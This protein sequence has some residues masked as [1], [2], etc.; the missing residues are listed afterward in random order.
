MPERYA[1]VS[2]GIT[3]AYEEVGDPGA[4]PL[5][6]VQGL[7]AQMIAW[8]DDFVRA[9]ADR[10]FRAVRFNNRDAGRSTHLDGMPDLR[11]I[12][13]GD[14]SKAP[15]TLEDM[16]ADTERLL[17][18]LAIDSAHVVG[19]SMGGMIAQVLA[20]R[21][22][23]RVLTLTSIMSTTGE[24]AVSQPTAAAQAT[25]FG[26]RPATVEEA[27]ERAVESARVIG[28]PGMLDEEWIRRR[29]RQSFER[30]FD[31]PG[32]ARQLA[33]IWASGNRT[34]SV[35]SIR[36]PT[37]V[38]HGTLDP[39]IPVTAGR[40]TAAAVPGAELIELE[41]MGHDLPR[42]LWPRLV[43]AIAAHAARAPAASQTLPP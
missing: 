24:R 20:A 11:A 21:A 3:L 18:E 16:A 35:R 6:L 31:P 23:E 17:D 32:F 39:L 41:E 1:H 36:V 4:S 28:S 42:P 7:G 30:G 8:H 40:A 19:V 26:P 27:E 38:I 34:E 29:A 9:L 15:Y 25:L 2:D 14:R 10:G 43:D 22:P 5:L 12:M 37:L 13:A 33:A